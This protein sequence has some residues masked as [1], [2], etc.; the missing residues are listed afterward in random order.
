MQEG[1]EAVVQG[2]R[3]GRR[4][5]TSAERRVGTSGG[6]RTGMWSGPGRSSRRTAGRMRPTRG[7]GGGQGAGDGRA[8]TA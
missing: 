5:G 7:I 4:G 1:I 6:W 2:R 8:L 3:W